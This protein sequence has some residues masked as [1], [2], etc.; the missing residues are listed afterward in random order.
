VSKLLPPVHRLIG[1]T[2]TLLIL[3]LGSWATFGHLDIVVQAQGKLVPDSAVKVSQ[4]VEAGPVVELLVHDGQTVK[5]G[6]LLARLDE[7]QP[8]KDA[9][10]LRV[11][12]ALAK[13]RL[14]A[15][16]NTLADRSSD[17]GQSAV[18]SEFSLRLAAYRQSL[19]GAQSALGK[20][21]ADLAAT[22]Q[23]L[24]KQQQT[25]KLA[26]HAEAANADLAKQGFIA[27]LIY[28]DKVKERIEREQD[29]RTVAANAIGGDAAVSQAR[30]TLASVTSD[31]HKQLAQERTQVL[32]QLQ[33]TE[34]ELAKAAHRRDLSEIRSPVDGVINSLAIKSPGQVV[35]AGAAL[36]TVVP[37]SDALVAE[38]WVRN[39]DVGFVSPGM[40]AK[41]KLAAFP[42]QK[43]GWLTGEVQVVGADSEV[44][45]HMRNAQGEP[46]FYKARITLNAQAL[47]RDGKSFP[48]KPGMQATADVQLGERSLL[49]YLTSPLK[50]A[51]LEAA[52]ER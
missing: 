16:D 1:G 9:E 26:Q 4:P 23:T 10:A 13:A 5:A 14:A 3:T 25:L 38:A 27:E 52:R 46:L 40:P 19:S 17:T 12:Q 24:V 45:E 30:S 34:A 8:A 49:E 43:Y 41:I 32:T 15:I 44:P 42:F 2:L 21:E 29:A 11:E 36:M 7:T 33:H 6:Q 50:K 20:A 51:V 22:R 28:Q 39:E 47:M 31:F 37:S 48:I 18:D 35:A